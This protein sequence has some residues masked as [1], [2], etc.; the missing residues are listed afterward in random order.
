[1]QVAE[2]FEFGVDEAGAAVEPESVRREQG[3]VD[4]SKPQP[5]GELSEKL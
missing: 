5:K 4:S 3:D 1:M 2:T